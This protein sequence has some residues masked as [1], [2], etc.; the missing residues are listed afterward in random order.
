MIQKTAASNS[1]Y[2][3]CFIDS[4]KI[5]L[6]AE[7]REIHSAEPMRIIRSD[8]LNVQGD[9]FCKDALCSEGSDKLWQHKVNALIAK[10]VEIDP[11]KAN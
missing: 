4:N 8:S 3:L 1:G 9:K 6:L 5:L 11:F 7:R 10:T 2:S